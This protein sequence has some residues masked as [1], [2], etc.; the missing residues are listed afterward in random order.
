MSLADWDD[1][2]ADAWSASTGPGLFGKGLARST[3]SLSAL[4]TSKVA[5][6]GF[7]GT[8]VSPAADVAICEVLDGLY[9]S[10]GCAAARLHE[11]KARKVTHVVNAAPTI[12]LNYHPEHLQ[13]MV[14][15]VLDGPQEPISAHFERVNAWVHAARTSGGCVLVHCHGGVSRAAALVLAY[16]MKS[17]NLGYEVALAR[18][19]SARP[20]V[21]PNPGFVQ[22]LLAFEQKANTLARDDSSEWPEPGVPGSVPA[23]QRR[24]TVKRSLSAHSPAGGPETPPGFSE[25]LL[26]MLLREAGNVAG[27]REGC[28]GAL[29]RSASL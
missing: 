22:Q 27:Q 10:S 21:Q 19:R 28:E 14:V 29:K 6:L 9:I 7:V 16:L 8:V 23:G 2:P 3:G 25:P 11:L 1:V 15:D 4:I 18:L 24:L 5:G 20:V 13:Y 17:E 12:E 26:T